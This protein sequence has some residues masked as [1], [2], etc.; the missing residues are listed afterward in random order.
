MPDL[1]VNR[2]TDVPTRETLTFLISRIPAGAQI[3]EVGC[4]DGQVACELLKC[5]YRVNGLD[6]DP[7]AVAKTQE[8]GVPAIVGSWPEFAGKAHFDAIV[9][10][11][12]LHHINPLRR[13]VIRARELLNPEGL[14]LIEDFAFDEA[15][16]ATV[17]WFVKILRLKQGKALIN[18]VADQLVTE[19]LSATDAMRTW[20]HNR[21][22]DLHSITTMNEAISERFGVRETQSVP[23]LYR[24]LVPVLANTSKAASFVSEV[25]QQESHSGER[26][27]I[28]L[29]GR[30]IVASR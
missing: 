5:G 2:P 15:D 29:L 24:Y 22:H 19:L 10:T 4:G 12:S 17:D 23:Y 1:I 26:G 13:A 28:V 21:G 16:E 20:R 8:R 30:R 11:R 25:F 27:E 9:F 18:P 3:L 14:L 6:S 7:E